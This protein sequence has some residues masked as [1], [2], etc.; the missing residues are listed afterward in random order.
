LNLSNDALRSQY[1]RGSGLM[2]YS[3][4]Y[5]RPQTELMGYSDQRISSELGGYES[6]ANYLEQ[7]RNARLEQ[8]LAQLEQ[9]KTPK[10]PKL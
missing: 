3:G 6:I 7:A 10:Q 2:N 8:S 4:D 1:S 9:E 5:Y